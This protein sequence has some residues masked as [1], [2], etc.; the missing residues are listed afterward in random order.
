[1]RNENINVQITSGGLQ[2]KIENIHKNII[3]A[4][5]KALAQM[6][7]QANNKLLDSVDIHLHNLHYRGKKKRWL[8]KLLNKSTQPLEI[9]SCWVEKEGNGEN[10]GKK[11]VQVVSTKRE[12]IEESTSLGNV[13]QLAKTCERG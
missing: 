13:C 7:E 4:L 9:R 10:G 3:P 1:M 2:Q 5:E 11:K 12:D 8:Q 6:E